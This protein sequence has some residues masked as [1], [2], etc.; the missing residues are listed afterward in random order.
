MAGVQ[1]LLPGNSASRVYDTINT[2]SRSARRDSA[3]LTTSAPVHQ[4]VRATRPS[5]PT[6]AAPWMITGGIY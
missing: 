1:P 5:F 2:S 4:R 3:Q 6:S